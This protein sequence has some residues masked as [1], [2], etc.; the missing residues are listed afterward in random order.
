M[1]KYVYIGLVVAAVAIIV[2]TLLSNKKKIEEKNTNNV[3]QT[4]FPVS[5]ATV[6][7]A[8]LDDE[9][10]LVGTT[11][12]NNEVNV[13]A[14]VNGRITKCNIRV[15]QNVK[16]G[17]VLYQVDDEVRLSQLKTAEANFEK[18][19][20]DSSRSKYLLS[21][22]SIS[23]AQWDAIELQYKLAEQQLVMAR[24]AYNDTRIKSPISG[25]VVARFA[26]V[27]S[28]V[29]NMQ[30]GTVV[31]TVMDLSKIKVKLQVAERDVVQMHE[32][33]SVRVNSEVFA[34][35]DFSG[36]ISSISAKGDEA[37]TY[38]V[39]VTVSNTGKSALRPGMF[40]RIHFMHID[41]GMSLFIPREAV[42]GSV[43][44]AQVYVVENNK[45]Y[46]RAVVLGSDV[47]GKVEVRSGLKNGDKVVT[48]GQNTI[49]DGYTVKIAS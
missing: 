43:K 22:K 47:N 37:H 40:A 36:T 19:Q 14:E 18:A 21:E 33:Q 27:G 9:L 10:S 12:A 3:V 49:N 30:S 17:E 28:M 41:K 1:K 11:L 24:R 15:G 23:A 31:C 35:E 6:S 29:N 5:V 7:E 45:A 2:F 8:K 34:G 46:K 16:A 42:V 25:V 13:T 44:D 39:E 26:D 48:A 32:G 20:K 38:P 4:E